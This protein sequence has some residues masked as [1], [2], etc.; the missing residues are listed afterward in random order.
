MYGGGYWFKN[1]CYLIYYLDFTWDNEI[2][3]KN[4]IQERGV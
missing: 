3:G 4:L 1:P 2:Y